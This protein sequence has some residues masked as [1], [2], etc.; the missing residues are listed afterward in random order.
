V[1]QNTVFSYVALSFSNLLKLALV[2]EPERQ[3]NKNL[4]KEVNADWFACK[5]LVLN[6]GG[7]ESRVA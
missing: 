3:L 1:Q 5:Q 2:P 4:R 7:V 6:I